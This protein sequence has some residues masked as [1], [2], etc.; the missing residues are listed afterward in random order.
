VVTLRC[1]PGAAVLL[2]HETRTLLEKCNRYLGQ[3]RIARFKFNPG[4]FSDQPPIP[5]HPAPD[6]APRKT[7]IALPDALEKLRNTRSE[8]MRRR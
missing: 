2:Q 6:T 1:E 5:S 8:L 3:G 7:G 4:T